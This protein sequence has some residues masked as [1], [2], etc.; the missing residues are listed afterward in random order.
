MSVASRLARILAARA[1]RW[2]F[3]TATARGRMLGRAAYVLDRRHR[4]VALANL[5]RAFPERDAAWHAGIARGAFEQAGRT[6][7]ETLWSARLAA[8][9]LEAV[10]R[11]GDLER[12]RAA[13][14]AGRGAILPT[15]HF[16]NW[17]LVGVVLGLLGMPLVSIARPLDDAALEEQITALRTRTGAAV[18]AKQ[19]AVRG[20]LRALRA[21]SPVAVLM[22][23]NTQRHEAV[24]V[25]FFG[26]PAATAPLVAHLHLRTGAPV[27][28]AFAVPEGPGYRLAVEEPV[29]V[30]TA[31]RVA[32]VTEV[33]AAVTRTIERQVRAHPE[34]WLW[35]HDRWRE[36]P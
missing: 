19:D 1:Q 14:A 3:A 21:G 2:S 18:V 15:A 26:R 31:D 4:G 30:A 10:F 35:M 25:P 16:G 36:Q 13:L 23:Q 32:A 34:A 22:D 27:L 6:V 24:F 5:R 11:P 29:T 20:A 7:L 8:G 28:P 12:V 33:T 9:D 17:E